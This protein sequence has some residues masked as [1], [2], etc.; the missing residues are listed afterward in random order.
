MA[1]R[2]VRRVLA[3]PLLFASS[4]AWGGLDNGNFDSDLGGWQ[5]LSPG[6]AVWATF[7]R[8]GS[9]ESGSAL[10]TDDA[11]EG[12]ARVY[13][14]EQC[15]SIAPG[16]TYRL[17][18]SGFLIGAGG[19]RLVFTWEVHPGEDCN[20]GVDGTGGAFLD[21]AGVWEDYAQSIF[22]SDA[23]AASLLIRLGIEKDAA[24]GS[25]Q[26]YFDVVMVDG[27]HIFSGGF[28]PL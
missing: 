4:L 8:N 9:S 12:G 21:S 24:G 15:I 23:P 26:G 5:L 28:D 13:P 22:V 6:V 27:D 19:G 17:R 3:L 14:L 1:E 2:N 11:A 16:A 7:D 10:L 25:V 18:A 20:G